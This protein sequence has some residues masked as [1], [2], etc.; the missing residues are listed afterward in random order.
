MEID[1]ITWWTD[2]PAGIVKTS[3][4]VVFFVFFSIINISSLQTKKDTS[5]N[6]VDPDEMAHNERSNKVLHSF[7]FWL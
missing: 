1:G 4:T 7:C 2:I 3:F 5:A 6:S